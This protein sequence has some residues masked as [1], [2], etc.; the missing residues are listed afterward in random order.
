MVLT[1][2]ISDIGQLSRILDKIAQIPNV[3]KARRKSK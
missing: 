2:E 3:M 1:L